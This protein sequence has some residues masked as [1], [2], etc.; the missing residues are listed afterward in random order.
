MPVK[1]SR[2]AWENIFEKVIHFIV[3][4]QGF[5][6]PCFI[7]GGAPRDAFLGK[8]VKDVDVFVN[9]PIEVADGLFLNAAKD[10]TSKNSYIGKNIKRVY[11][12][13]VPGCP[14]NVQIINDGRITHY[15]DDLFKTFDLGICMF[16]WSPLH[17][18][19]M[20]DDRAAS[21]SLKH[22]ITVIGAANQEHI[23]RILEKYPGYVLVYG[24][25]DILIPEIP[26]HLLTAF[27]RKLKNKKSKELY[28]DVEL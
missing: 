25:E 14:V 18:R 22:Q 11:N 21:D 17:S 9:L 20:V 5:G 26:D 8:H 28:E 19:I 2:I 16:R 12:I 6:G 27:Y 3:N 10:N 24:H 13:F 15:T 1:L 4:K 23:D 7:A